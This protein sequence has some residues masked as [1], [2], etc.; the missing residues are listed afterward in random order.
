MSRRQ[1]SPASNP[2]LNTRPTA[3]AVAVAGALLGTPLTAL[4]L[5]TGGE[6]AAGQAT[7]SQP[8]ATSLQINQATQKA[9]LNWQS[10]SIGSTEAVNFSQPS[11]SAIAL[12][13]VLGNNPSEIFG[14]LSANG[15]VFLVNPSGVL[16]GRSASVDVGSLVATTLSIS[17]Q[18]FL[19][20]RYVFSNGGGAGSVRNEGSII[21]ANG[22]TALMAP[23]VSNDGLIA[24][25]LGSVTLAAADR[26]SLDMIGDGLISVSV[27]QAA[28]NA[29]AINSG[30]IEAD[31]GNVL[32][33]ARS[34]NALLDT[35]VNNAGV[36]RANSLIERDGEIVLDGGSAGGV[37]SSSGTLQAA[38]VEAGTTGGTVKILG[39]KV[40]LFGT[41]TIDASGDAGGGIVL[42]G[43]NYQGHGPET[44]A[45]ATIVGPDVL[46]DASAVSAGNGGMVVVWSDGMTRAHGRISARGGEQSGNGGFIETSGKQHLSI[47]GLRIDARAPLGT[48]G[49]WL[50][51]PFDVTIYDGDGVTPPSEGGAFTGTNPLTWTPDASPSRVA[52]AD[53]QTNL[54]SADVIITTTG[55]TPEGTEPGDITVE[56]GVSITIPLLTTLTLNA[57]RDIHIQGN[58]S[59]VGALTG[60][61]ELNIGQAGGGG[62]LFVSSTASLPDGVTTGTATVTGGAGTDGVNVTRDVDMTLTNALLTVT[63]A[64]AL[65]LSSVEAATLSGGASANAINASTFTGTTVMTGAG[66]ADI[67]TGGTGDDSFRFANTDFTSAV[68]VVGGAG[69]NEIRITDDATVVDADF[70]AVTGV[71]TL[72]LAGTGSQSVTL[73]TLAE[74]AGVV[75]V[76]AAAGNASTINVGGY[77]TAGVTITTDVG[78]DTITGGGGADNVS[79]GAG[80]DTLTGG[81]GADSLDAGTGTGD[82][83]AET[84]DANFTLA[85]AS[86]VIGAEGTDTLT[87]VEVAYLIGGASNNSFTVSGW[88]G[89]GTIDGQGGTGDT[90]VASND[91]SFTLTDTSLARTGGQATLTLANTESATLTG[92]GSANAFVLSGW[93]GTGSMVG[94]GGA[95]T[96]TGP[97]TGNT[98]NVTSAGTGNI[99]STVSFSAMTN[100][101]GG[102]AA[103]SFVFS[104]GASIGGTLTGGTGSD[105]LNLSAYTAATNVVLTASAANGYS[106]TVGAPVTGGFSEIDSVTGGTAVNTLSGIA[107]TDATWSSSG[108]NSGTYQAS[109]GTLL[110]FGN[111]ANWQ[112]STGADTIT[113]A[114]ITGSLAD[115][116]NTAILSG[117][118]TTGGTQNYGGPTTLAGNT[119]VSGSAITFN[120]PVDGGFSL[121]A[122]SPGATSF[123]GAIGSSTA[124]ASI[125]TDAG[126]TTS[127]AGGV[128]TTGSILFNDSTTAAG[129]TFT[130][131]GGGT[132]QVFNAGQTSPGTVSTTGNVIFG[133]GTQVGTSSLSPLVFSVVP[134]GLQLLSAT[135]MFFSASAIPTTL[136][137]PAGSSVT[138]VINGSPTLLAANAAQLQAGQAAS[139]AQTSAAAATV[140]EA[141]ETFGTDSVA[142]QVEYGFAGDVGTTPPMDHRLDETG[143]SVP[144]CL[145][146]SREGVPCK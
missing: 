87:G 146:E 10:F 1:T 79:S 116:G 58:A 114:N 33:T 9:V 57:Q 54:A 91:V 26:V 6:V 73:A 21:T 144:A 83:V 8:T 34:A 139:A 134:A 81:A 135:T 14:R 39:D 28:L 66:G 12:N 80:D 43:G 145:N 30:R 48:T 92:G 7:I 129:L 60:A 62:T 56:N 2:P 32:L 61:L 40:G 78:S 99:N 127:L 101:V 35:V 119:T 93:S 55:G 67:L 23:Q 20:G 22:Y 64:Y 124:L 37:V 13:R 141:N 132:V 122:N 84:R 121:T 45:S 112:L 46:I 125:T 94:G 111:F 96:L 137:F 65:S 49:T 31:G 105:A 76:N 24:A 19:A 131:T 36:I 85:S 128:T 38:G 5:P 52:D 70:T 50:L 4:A 142:E 75:T 59:I 82:I 108:S 71:Q 123:F 107:A 95:D 109:G 104:D 3:L 140:Q 42:I 77:V 72:F 113:G 53:I 118:I 29:S 25:R 106:G 74:A 47:A 100:L 117:V 126:G 98:W 15:Q 143:I 16:F 97:N 44:N 69:A 120:G 102:T 130:S 17:D 27:D 133:G 51:D 136:V 41:A 103:D 89:S 11:A 110:S 115:A 138:G 90:V 88:T 86:L 18:D 68:T 63:G